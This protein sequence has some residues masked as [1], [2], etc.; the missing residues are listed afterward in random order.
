MKVLNVFIEKKRLTQFHGINQMVVGEYLV[1]IL[2]SYNIAIRNG[3]L[4]TN[5]DIFYIGHHNTYNE[6]SEYKALLGSRLVYVKQQKKSSNIAT[7]NHLISDS[8]YIKGN[9]HGCFN[10][11]EDWSEYIFAPSIYYVKPEYGARSLNQFIV[12][13]TKVS[14]GH[15]IHML[16][17]H[18]EDKDDQAKYLAELVAQANGHI[19]HIK[20]HERYENEHA[21]QNFSFCVHEQIP[22]LDKEYRVINCNYGK[23]LYFLERVRNAEN[24][25]VLSNEINY[26]EVRGV[27]LPDI[28]VALFMAFNEN[29]FFH[30]SVDLVTTIDG[31]WS[32]IE[33]SNQFGGADIPPNIKMEMVHTVL[34]GLIKRVYPTD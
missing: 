6:L 24:D 31:K 16:R 5:I 2:D 13:S 19:K 12:D 29:E 14:L 7:Y 8:R 21:V 17:K 28:D 25:G 33:T 23:K 18:T 9:I 1:N 26:V 11:N 30:G 4:E 34:D 3:K 22:N 15:F 10:T 20:G 32:I 27:P